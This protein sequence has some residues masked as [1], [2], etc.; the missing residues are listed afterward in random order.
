MDAVQRRA[1]RREEGREGERG[2]SSVGERE[3]RGVR[4]IV[5]MTDPC[6]AW[7]DRREQGRVRWG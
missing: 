4:S 3:E 5:D 2:R 6:R 1:D 7:P